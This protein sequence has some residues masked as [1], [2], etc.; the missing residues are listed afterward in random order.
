ME[1]NE[2]PQKYKSIIFYWI[3]NL[4]GSNSKLVFNMLVS[5]AGGLLYS[6]GV[7]PAVYVLAI[8]GVLSPIL[9][10]LCLYSLIPMLGN[11]RD[12]PFPGIFR[13]PSRSAF[14][15]ILD[16]TIIVTLALLIQLNVLNYFFFRLLQTVVFPVMMLFILRIMIMSIANSNDQRWE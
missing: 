3:E 4:V 13:S 8:F 2:T 1:H 7:W 14:L 6:F 15:M 5:A 11:T 16:M 9:F 12:N 10:T